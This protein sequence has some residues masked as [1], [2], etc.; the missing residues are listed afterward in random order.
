[1]IGIVDVGIG[2]QGSIREAIYSLGADPVSVSKPG[3][4]ETVSHL[5][6]PGVGA[7]S[8]AVGCLRR[9]GLFEPIQAYVATGRPLLGICLGMQLL[10]SIGDEDGLSEGLG[11]IP[12]RVSKLQE[13]A[14]LRIP[15]VGWNEVRFAQAHAIFAGV[16]DSMDFY[17]VHSY[18]FLP[19]STSNV[20][21]RTHHGDDV[22]CAVGRDNV[23]GLQF[24]PEKSQKN[25]LRMLENFCDWDGQ[26]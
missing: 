22:V 11:L 1:M 14:D 19:E 3:D 15:H 12:G 21:G 2:N 13:Q 10:A 26:C 8:H 18:E 4:L 17:F 20:L 24:H 25:G 23:V 9:S 7:F 5:I 6:L 16:K